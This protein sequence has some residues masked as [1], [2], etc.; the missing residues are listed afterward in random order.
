MFCVNCQQETNNPK[1]CSRPCSA[2]YN[3]S[4]YPKRKKLGRCLECNM[5][6]PAANKYCVYH[7]P[8]AYVERSITIAELKAK[9]GKYH[10]SAD[11]RNKLRTDYRNSN[12]P[13]FCVICGYDK[14]YELS[15]LIPIAKFSDD[16]PMSVVN[17][18]DNVAPLCPTHH[19][20][21]DHSL[22]NPADVDK[23]IDTYGDSPFVL[24]ILF[25]MQQWYQHK[26]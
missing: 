2:R 8:R 22:L 19:W 4:R 3:N 21:Y 13:K 14:F 18:F 26:R 9:Y 25:A 7:R 5:E 1:F 10:Y 24:H 6:I 23:A 20:E 11:I 15:H 16:T 12:R 17:D